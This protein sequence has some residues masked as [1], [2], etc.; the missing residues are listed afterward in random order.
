MSGC[1]W[2]GKI[3]MALFS[4]I[5]LEMNLSIERSGRACQMWF[6]EDLI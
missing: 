1:R 5:N 4:K 3:G 2:K 6:L